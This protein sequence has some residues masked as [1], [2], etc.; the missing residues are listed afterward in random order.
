MTGIPNGGFESLLKRLGRAL[1]S[2]RCLNVL[3]LDR[4]FVSNNLQKM[5]I[6]QKD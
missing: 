4:S 3:F 5:G 1:D 6:I 2:I